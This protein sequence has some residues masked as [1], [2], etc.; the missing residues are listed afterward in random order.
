MNG[1]VL[2]ELT[3]LMQKYGYVIE[4]DDAYIRVMEMS[5]NDLV[6]LYEVDPGISISLI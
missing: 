3:S 1:I 6:S 4:S 2:L 5:E